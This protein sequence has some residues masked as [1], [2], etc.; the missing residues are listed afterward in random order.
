MNSETWSTI[1]EFA[2]L[3]MIIGIL[4]FVVTHLSQNRTYRYALLLA[5]V[6]VF[7]ILWINLAV[8]IIGEPEHPANLIYIGVPVVAVIGSI[9]AQFKSA[10]MARAMN[11]AA[12]AQGV[13]AAV[14]LLIARD[15]PSRWY[16]SIL[17]LNV[18]LVLVWMGSA[19]LFRKAARSRVHKE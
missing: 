3:A 8:G 12:T 18:V 16:W 10:G 4:I 17:I 7:L 5:F 1:A 13:V 6:P 2:G 15:E 19:A 11:L 14:T 9:V